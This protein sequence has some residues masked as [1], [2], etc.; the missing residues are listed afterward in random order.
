MLQNPD[1]GAVTLIDIILLVRLSAM[2]RQVVAS[3]L[4]R[5]EAEE[6]I[7]RQSQSLREGS[8]IQ[9]TSWLVDPYSGR[10]PKRWLFDGNTGMTIVRLTYFNFSRGS[11]H[12]L[13]VYLA[14]LAF[15]DRNRNG[16][17]ILSYTKLAMITGVG[18]HLI[19]DA[20]THI[21]Q[22]ELISFRQAD[23]SGNDP[24]RTN[25]YL[26]KGLN[27]AWTALAQEY[28]AIGKNPRTRRAYQGDLEDFCSFVGLTATDEFRAV[29]RSHVLA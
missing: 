27:I 14:L 8:S 22:M 17:T 15:R 2:S 18:R 9:L 23:F 12:A 28:P 24:D 21:Y 5:L 7:D 6:L 16:L 10:I 3:A 11:L 13:K 19:G 4:K 26:I 25:R 20:I 29:T 1:V